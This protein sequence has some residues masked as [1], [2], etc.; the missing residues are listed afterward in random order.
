MKILN[1]LR[2]KLAM[3]CV[4]GVLLFAVV[5]LTA[6]FVQERGIKNASKKATQQAEIQLSEVAGRESSKIALDVKLM[7]RAL[8]EST[9]NMV[10]ADLN[11]ARKVMSIRGDADFADETVQWDAINQYTKKVMKIE[12]PKMTVGGDWLGQNREFS[13]RSIVVDE[14]NDLVGGTCTIFQ[15]MN[16]EGD[17]LRVSTNVK[18]LDGKRAVG[19]FIPAVNPDGS[20]NPV[21]S[22]VMK[23][24]TF[25]GRAYVVNAWY[26]TAYEPIKNQD[27]R[28]VGVLYVGVK[29]ENV[30]SL[31]R[32]I[33]EIVVGT[34]GSIVVLGGTGGQKCKVVVEDNS[35]DLNQDLTDIKDES[36]N[37]YYG[38]LVE[39]ATSQP[40]RAHTIEYI[41]REGRGS[42][43]MIASS[44]YFPK[45]DWVIITRAPKSDFEAIVNTVKNELGNIDNRVKS[46][47]QV[48]ITVTVVI[49]VAVAALSWFAGRQLL[50]PILKVTDTLK[51]ISEGDGDLTARLDIDTND[52]AG[53]LARSFNTFVRKIESII[54]QLAQLSHTLR[55]DIKGLDSIAS[56][57]ATG[58]EHMNSDSKN[59]SSSS[60]EMSESL[61]S[62]SHGIQ[63]MSD[64]VFSVV[65]AI[66]QMSATLGEVA[67]NCSHGS[68]IAQ[69]AYQKSN[70]ASEIMAEL[71]NASNEI[72][73]VSELISGIADQTNLLA[74]NATIEAASAGEAG[75]GFAVVASEVKE[76]AKQTV[77]AT[78]RIQQQIEEIQK[79][80]SQ[81]VSAIGEVTEII[82]DVNGIT[83]TIASAVEQQS[84]TTNEIAGN[85]AST[86]STVTDVS[87]RVEGVAKEVG[88]LNQSIERLNSDIGNLSQGASESSTKVSSLRDM[89][90]DID[91]LVGQFKTKDD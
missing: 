12:L 45:W 67:K 64:S 27:G 57:M 90:R 75:K 39:K 79:S 37:R 18:K 51:D 35:Y 83:H 76:L 66:E 48:S 55:G 53:E 19:T 68:N 58:T 49:L 52:E 80:T 36:G 21:I 88:D 46:L 65:A 20:A 40:D 50:N 28:I 26:V 81:A 7:C 72:G 13:T 61:G 6:V 59:I 15:R 1:S 73:N 16:D 32:G 29:Q 82:G 11:V 85:I 54:V 42:R 25:K 78:D 24:E 87:S 43:E 74:L 9:Q 56:E 22:T 10:T 31:R 44:V 70:S 30:E 60:T 23:G 4:G 47:L 41:E 89:V 62:A 86:S 63:N 17:M 69:D 91:S 5:I 77:D 38:D 33:K 3:L 71:T 8:Q 14:V 34:T 2:G 84:A